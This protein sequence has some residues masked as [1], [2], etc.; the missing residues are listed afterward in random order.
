VEKECVDDE[1]LR[2]VACATKVNA[3]PHD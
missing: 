1:C 2:G 3:G